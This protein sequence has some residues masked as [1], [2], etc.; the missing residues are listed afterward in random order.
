MK[1]IVLAFLCFICFSAFAQ[2]PPKFLYYVSSANPDD[3][4]KIGIQPRGDNV[5]LIS[6][7]LGLSGASGTSNSAYISLFDDATQAATFARRR[8]VTQKKT[9][10]VFKIR[11]N[12]S[13]FNAYKGVNAIYDLTDKTPTP[14]QQVFYSANQNIWVNYGHIFSEQIV[15]ANAIINGDVLADL[16]NLPASHVNP[17][18]VDAQTAANPTDFATITAPLAHPENSTIDGSPPHIIGNLP[19]AVPD[20]LITQADPDNAHPLTGCFQCLFDAFG[21][22]GGGT[23]DF[24]AM[25]N[26]T[27]SQTDL[28]MSFFDPKYQ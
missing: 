6:H 28:P 12:E 20:G 25:F 22:G 15:H 7:F 23:F 21:G 2:S 13:A 8:A 10:Y 18:Y 11:A 27:F 26:A 16:D 17:H 3:L 19:G 4:F 14:Q 24:G 5:N 9:F 1:K